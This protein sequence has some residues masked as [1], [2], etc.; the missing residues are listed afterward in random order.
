MVN[1]NDFYFST[2][3]SLTPSIAVTSVELDY[4][5]SGGSQSVDVTA[6][7][8]W[9]VTA[10]PSWIT[11]TPSSYSGSATITVTASSNSGAY[12]NGIV[13][14]S[15]SGASATIDVYQDGPI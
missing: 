7:V 1:D 3:Q 13:T 14:L 12:R 9:S 6:N 2:M 8:A 10:K 4:S 5:A 11:V 15:G